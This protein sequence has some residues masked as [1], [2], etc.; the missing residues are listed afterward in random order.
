[1]SIDLGRRLISAGLV[2]AEEVEAA[3]FFSVARG[4]PFARV[5]LDRGALTERGLEEELERVGGLG[6]RQVAGASEIVARL[7]R[8]MCRRLAALPTRVDP[9]TGTIDVAAA[10]PLDPHVAAEF[11]F[12]LGAPI[13]VLRAPIAAIEE[14]IRRLELDEPPADSPRAR[15]RRVT[16]PFPHGAPQSSIP[17]PIAEEAPIPLVRKVSGGNAEGGERPKTATLVP[18][19]GAPPGQRPIVAPAARPLPIQAPA[20]RFHA[21]APQEA[22]PAPRARVA[23]PV[24]RDVAGEAPS[25]SFPSTPPSGARGAAPTTT[26][27]RT[28]AYGTPLSELGIRPDAYNLEPDSEP[29]S[30]RIAPPAEDPIAAARAAAAAEP[31]SEP[32][33]SPAPPTLTSARNPS[34]TRAEAPAPRAE[35]VAVAPRAEPAPP[36]DVRG[37]RPDMPGYAP[38]PPAVRRPARPSLGDIPYPGV[39]QA[40]QVGRADPRRPQPE[41]EPASPVHAALTEDDD[42]PAEPVKRR[43]RMPDLTPI[44]DALERAPA[45]DDVIR[46]AMRGMRLVARRLAVFAVKRDGFHGWICNVEF[47]DSEVFRQVVIPADSP[48]VLATATATA[49]YLGPIPATPAHEGML[50]VMERAS[51]DVAAVT[52][53]VA[54]RPALVLVCDELEDTMTGTRFL[55]ELGRVVGERLARLISK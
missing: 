32:A 33:P 5:L 1:V 9:A 52:V 50:R 14:A 6:L 15:P 42:P 40:P 21:R 44:A 17:P 13:R 10:D 34:L 18:P 20:P 24:V 48:S 29:A 37:L 7:P 39:R 12:H 30:Y 4:V 53:R 27:R 31:D 19:A 45:R 23:T 54:G 16:P 2:S 43:V 36:V 49:L 25:V 55:G 28:P 3:L 46:V 22:A 47:G 26:E 11:A 35:P 8:A 51:S 41:P 38:G